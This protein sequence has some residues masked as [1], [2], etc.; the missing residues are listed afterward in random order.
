MRCA[1]QG[2]IRSAVGEHRPAH[3]L[4]FIEDSI[5]T[6]L[7]TA[8]AELAGSTPGD[9]R[10]F[11][12][13]ELKIRANTLVMGNSIYPIENISTVTLS[14]LR[15]PVPVIVWI[16][17]GVGVMCMLTVVLAIIGLPLV[18]FAVY[19]LYL[20]WKSKAA[21]DFSLAIRMNGG[22]SATVMSN[23]EAFLKGIALELYEVIEFEKVSNTTFNIDRS[24]KIDNITGSVVPVGG[25]NGDIVNHVSGI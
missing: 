12:H 7:A 2:R 21:A 4:R 18:A 10:E 20:N 1:P 9:K 11:D 13:G 5:M 17:L 8:A 24:I 22:N 15:Q 25:V 16:L 3:T 19:L 14:D 6:S 23:N